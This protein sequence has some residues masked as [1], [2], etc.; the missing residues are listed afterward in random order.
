[1][2]LIVYLVG[3]ISIAIIDRYF[4]LDNN[5]LVTGIDIDNTNKQDLVLLLIELSELLLVPSIIVF[6]YT[7][8]DLEEK[9]LMALTASVLGPN[10]K[11]LTLSSISSPSKAKKTRKEKKK[12]EKEKPSLW[13][14]FFL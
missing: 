6:N 2:S 9:V 10:F 14:V 13:I 4:D 12:K 1:M 11:S 8:L 5:N 7:I 3:D